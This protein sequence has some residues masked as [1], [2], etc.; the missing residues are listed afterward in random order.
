ML[1]IFI[2]LETANV[3]WFLSS[4]FMMMINDKFDHLC[5]ETSEKML[6]SGFLNRALDQ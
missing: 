1:L 5:S 6:N 3:N 2:D 4:L